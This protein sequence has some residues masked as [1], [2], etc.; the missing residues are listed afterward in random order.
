MTEFSTHKFGSGFEVLVYFNKVVAT[1]DVTGAKITIERGQ[2][3]FAEF[4][5]V[6]NL[7]VSNIDTT[8][9]REDRIVD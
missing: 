5:G 7:I 9:F 6:V 4:L 8:K 2:M 1:S 3:S